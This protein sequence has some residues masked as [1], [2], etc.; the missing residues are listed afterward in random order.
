[1]VNQSHMIDPTLSSALIHLQQT[2]TSIKSI[3]ILS[4]TTAATNHLKF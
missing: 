1:L 2:M 4:T 3:M